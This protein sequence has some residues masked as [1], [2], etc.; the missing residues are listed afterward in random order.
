MH[1]TRCT[2]RACFRI[3]MQKERYQEGE[4]QMVLGQ[5]APHHGISHRPGPAC[6]VHCPFPWLLAAPCWVPVREGPASTSMQRGSVAASIPGSH[7]R[8][9]RRRR[10]RLAIPRLLPRGMRLAQTQPPGLYLPCFLRPG[11]GSAF[12]RSYKLCGPSPTSLFVS[13]RLR[14]CPHFPPSLP[15][16]SGRIGAPARVSDRC[17]DGAVLLVRGRTAR[18][19]AGTLWN[20]GEEDGDVG[21]RV[22]WAGD[23]LV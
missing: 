5:V 19:V 8:T 18:V 20:A 11:T 15:P 16:P 22:S 10:R 1:D 13:A 3:P 2:M 6:G 9:R 7:P 4:G 23:C 12:M 17:S 14:V 21:R